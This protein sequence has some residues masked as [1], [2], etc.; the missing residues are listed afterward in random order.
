MFPNHQS[1]VI[2]F[3]YHERM[4]SFDGKVVV[5]TG[6]AGN[7][8]TAVVNAFNAAGANVALIDHKPGR[9]QTLF[10]T[11]ANQPRYLLA[12]GVDVNNLEALQRAAQQ[13]VD[14][15]GQIDV[16]VN[17][18]GGYQGEVP[19]HELSPE[20]WDAMFT[21]NARSAFLVSRAVVPFMLARQS[22]K[23]VHTSAR[24]GLRGSAKSA[25]YSAAKSA[26]IRLTESLSE[27]LRKKGISVN[28]VLPGTIDTPQN[29]TSMPQA[30]TSRWA[31]PEAVADVIL[32]LASDE[33]RA[34]NG[35]AIPL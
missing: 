35:V 23:I 17:T 25:P 7:L 16:L 9:L 12:D 6:A 22:G 14:R 26:V 30:D 31:Q 11:L 24:S 18:V 28:C 29:R 15:F 20:Q 13:T 5:V 34:L 10:P 32:F 2:V 33:A 19:V 3:G 8:G 1:S 21:L 27:E 4:F